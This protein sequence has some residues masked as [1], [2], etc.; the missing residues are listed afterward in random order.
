MFATRVLL[1]LPIRASQLIV[2]ESL[3]EQVC[4]SLH[5][6]GISCMMMLDVLYFYAQSRSTMPRTVHVGLLMVDIYLSYERIGVINKRFPR[7]LGWI[8]PQHYYCPSARFTS[9]FCGIG[10]VSRSYACQA[11]RPH[12]LHRLTSV[13]F[14]TP[15]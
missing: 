11:T 15:T 7:C 14:N 8:V 12:V 9:T 4:L 13:S 1:L 3:H 6:Q 10:Y 2:I 5:R